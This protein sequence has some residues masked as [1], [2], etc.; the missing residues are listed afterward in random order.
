MYKRQFPDIY[1]EIPQSGFEDI[2]DNECSVTFPHAAKAGGKGLGSNPNI[3]LFQN[4]LV[5]DAS[6]W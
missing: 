4:V 2:L 3:G 6:H 5:D 1:E